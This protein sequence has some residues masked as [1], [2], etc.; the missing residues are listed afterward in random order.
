[1][2][3]LTLLTV[4]IVVINAMYAIAMRKNL[5][6]VS[7]LQGAEDFYLRKMTPESKWNNN[8]TIPKIYSDS[9]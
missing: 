5:F 7:S 4:T 3:Y 8:T 6:A 9:L 2:R 1:M